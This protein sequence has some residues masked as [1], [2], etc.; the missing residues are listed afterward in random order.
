MSALKS[1]P[2]GVSKPCYAA[3]VYLK[4]EMLTR[5]CYVILKNREVEG[6]YVP[7]NLQWKNMGTEIS[8]SL[9]RDGPVVYTSF[10][11]G[12]RLGDESVDSPSTRGKSTEVEKT[13]LKSVS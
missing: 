8:I 6:S 2:Y 4:M 1:S 9:Q 11:D 10:V 7:R 13:G 12:R 5:W 3:N